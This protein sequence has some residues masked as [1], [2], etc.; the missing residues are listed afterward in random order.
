MHLMTD[1]FKVLPILP[2]NNLGYF[3]KIK[4]WA[5]IYGN[6]LINYL[7]FIWLVASNMKDKRIIRLKE[8]HFCTSGI[9]EKSFWEQFI[10][11]FK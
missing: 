6:G 10:E 5:V 9:P 11:I 1:C 4:L 3:S 2:G 8:A 7:L